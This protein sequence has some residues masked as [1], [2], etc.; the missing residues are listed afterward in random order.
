M[1][2]EKGLRTRLATVAILILVFVAG[3][4]V[5]YAVDRWTGAVALATESSG[6]DESERRRSRGR[7]IN[8]VDL[9]EMQEVQVDSILEHHRKEMAELQAYYHPRYW[10]IIDS[11]RESIKEVLTDD[12]R[13]RYDSLLAASDRRRR[14]DPPP[15]PPPEE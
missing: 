8:R 10:G 11:T 14:D 12:Q 13:M 7:I 2:I 5:G 15:P 1:T 6:E 4:A 9:T 3:T